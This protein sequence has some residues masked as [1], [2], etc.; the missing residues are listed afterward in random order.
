MPLV[1][2]GMLVSL[3]PPPPL[4]LR[5]LE[6]RQRARHPRETA[7]YIFACLPS[8]P[9]P[10]AMQP[11]MRVY[12]KYNDA[13]LFAIDI[14]L[15]RTT[16][17]PTTRVGARRVTRLLICCFVHHARLYYGFILCTAAARYEAR[18]SRR[19]DDAARQRGEG[20]LH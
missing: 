20:V 15:P 8:H 18:V 13:R 5:V 4:L 16:P 17:P 11:A 2:G 9:P 7:K 1:R 10:A 3:L 12:R 6:N 14:L 19:V